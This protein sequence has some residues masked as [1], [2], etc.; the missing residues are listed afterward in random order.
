MFPKEVG[1]TGYHSNSFPPM[2]G[3]FLDGAAYVIL[4]TFS[5][6]EVGRVGVY[7]PAAFWH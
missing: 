1:R 4:I 7:T 6:L 2:S 3:K 5:F